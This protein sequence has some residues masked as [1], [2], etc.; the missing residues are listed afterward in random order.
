MYSAAQKASLLNNSIKSTTLNNSEL[1][2]ARRS[3]LS[4]MFHLTSSVYEQYT[5]QN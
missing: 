5:L 3:T 4:H 2:S 1:L